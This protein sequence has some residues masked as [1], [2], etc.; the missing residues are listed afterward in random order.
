MSHPMHF[1]N[2]ARLQTL[3]SFGGLTLAFVLSRSFSRKSFTLWK[4]RKFN[5]SDCILH[6]YALT[7]CL[8]IF[9]NAI[10]RVFKS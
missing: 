3:Q 5:Q 10:V 1:K 2:D 7:F 9:F 6:V 4:D 8:S